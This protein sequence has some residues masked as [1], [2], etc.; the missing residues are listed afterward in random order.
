MTLKQPKLLQY[1]STCHFPFTT[2]A[3]YKIYT[4]LVPSGPSFGINWSENKVLGL[5]QFLSECSSPSSNAG[6]EGSY[7]DMFVRTA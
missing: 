5:G 2:S 3:S 4:S 6:V 7:H 1:K